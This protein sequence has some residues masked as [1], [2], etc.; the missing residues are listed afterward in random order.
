MI[1]DFGRTPPRRH[2]SKLTAEVR[3]TQSRFKFQKLNLDSKESNDPTQSSSSDDPSG[4]NTAMSI[5]HGSKLT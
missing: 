1:P 2:V 5:T 3:V 4:S